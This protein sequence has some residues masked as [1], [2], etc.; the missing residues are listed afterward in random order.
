MQVPKNLQCRSNIT[1]ARTAV[2]HR[3]WPGGQE[4][5]VALVKPP[6]SQGLAPQGPNG[7]YPHPDIIH[8]YSFIDS[9]SINK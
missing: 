8:L 5:V 2:T 3:L 4:E 6:V 7:S 9:L 1:P